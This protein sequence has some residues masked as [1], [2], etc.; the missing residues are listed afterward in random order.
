MLLFPSTRGL[1]QGDSHSPPLFV[2]VMEA[3][4]ILIDRV[5]AGGYLEGFSVANPNMS[6]LKVSNLLFADDTLIF[7]GSDWDQLYNLKGVLM[8]FEAVSRL[9]LNLGKS[10]IVPVGPVPNVHVLAQVLGGRIT[11]IPIKYL[12]LPLGARYKSKEIWNPILEKM[13]KKLVG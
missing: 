2:L 9:T 7:C 13:E 8:Y 5:V 11:S 1:K 3:L 6:D 10:E 12:G 4:S